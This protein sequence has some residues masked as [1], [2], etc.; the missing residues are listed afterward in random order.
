MTET[1]PIPQ[2]IVRDTLEVMI[3]RHVLTVRNDRMPDG[4]RA[5]SQAFL[6]MLRNYYRDDGRSDGRDAIVEDL[7][8]QIIIYAE[9][10]YRTVARAM[11]AGNKERLSLPIILTNVAMVVGIS[12]C[13]GNGLVEKMA[14]QDPSA[15]Q[16]YLGSGLLGALTLATF[17]SHGAIRDARR[18]RQAAGE[19]RYTLTTTDVMTVLDA[20][21]D[22]VKQSLAKGI[23]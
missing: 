3:G 5:E 13:L 21:S 22:A 23:A 4:R 16:A 7:R 8:R 20:Y 14:H 10:H 19:M 17:H 12:Y 15:G 18:L 1:T 9:E 6:R 11:A 2:R